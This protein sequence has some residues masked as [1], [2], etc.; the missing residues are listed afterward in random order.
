M[1]ISIIRLKDNNELICIVDGILDGCVKTVY[2]YYIRYN[3][4][5]NIL[6]MLPYCPLSDETKFDIETSRVEFMV[7]PK[8]IVKQKYLDMIKEDYIQDNQ[9]TP[10][11]LNYNQTMFVDGNLTSH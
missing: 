9:E 11:E 2:P 4:N 5:E 10:K 3:H 7:E 6:G 8:R 1:T